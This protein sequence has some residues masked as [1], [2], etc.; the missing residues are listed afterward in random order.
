MAPAL[1]MRIFPVAEDGLQKVSGTVSGRVFDFRGYNVVVFGSGPLIVFSHLSRINSTQIAQRAE[2]PIESVG[3][4]AYQLTRKL[5]LGWAMHK[6]SLP[7]CNFCGRRS[8]FDECGDLVVHRTGHD[9]A[10]GEPH[11]RN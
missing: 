10:S 6:W 8:N 4:D 2:R 5:F 7:E 1:R 9:D 11:S 3:D